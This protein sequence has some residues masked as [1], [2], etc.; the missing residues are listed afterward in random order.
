MNG[1]LMELE[2]LKITMFQLEY[3]MS[4]SSSLKCKV[5]YISESR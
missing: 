5:K 3:L 1:T 4:C 2:Q